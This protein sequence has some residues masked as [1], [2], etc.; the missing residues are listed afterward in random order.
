ME[1][2][3]KVD[4][5]A[6]ATAADVE[7][8]G[9]DGALLLDSVEKYTLNLKKPVEFEGKTYD[10]LHFDFGTLTG[11]DCR[12]IDKELKAQGHFA[13]SRKLD[14]EFLVRACARA[15]TED[16]G[17]EIFDFLCARDYCFITNYAKKFF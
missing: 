4:P 6:K 15:C 1:N 10:E 12:M 17:Y 7:A 16:V 2:V 3:I 11:R 13:V 8:A 5:N 9:G 14:D